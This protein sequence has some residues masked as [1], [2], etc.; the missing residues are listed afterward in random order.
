VES[1]P[2]PAIP[3]VLPTPTPPS[4]GVLRPKRRVAAVRVPDPATAPELAPFA[5]DMISGTD[6]EPDMTT[7]VVIV[8]RPID[9][10]A[11]VAIAIERCPAEPAVPLASGANVDERLRALES[12]LADALTRVREARARPRQLPEPEQPIPE[13]VIGPTVP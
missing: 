2:E 3:V 9:H 13:L 10:S 6:L 12:R 8:D 7:P 1:E 4:T 5:A 11:P